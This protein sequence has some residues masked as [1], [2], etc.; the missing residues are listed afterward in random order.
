MRRR[1]LICLG[2]ACLC[3]QAPA[4]GA[5]PAPPP[6]PL[7]GHRLAAPG[8]AATLP[9]AADFPPPPVPFHDATELTADALVD[10]VLARN[11]SLAQMTAAWASWRRMSSTSCPAARA[12]AAAFS[13]RKHR[14]PG[15]EY[16]CDTSRR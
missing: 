12:S 6:V 11:P 13:P 15:Q 4:R 1:I 8:P 16:F 3:L 10:Q 14:L 2:A 5:G 7:A 9:A